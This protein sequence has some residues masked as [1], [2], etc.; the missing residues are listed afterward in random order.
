MNIKLHDYQ[1]CVIH[2][3]RIV[4]WYIMSNYREFLVFKFS[5]AFNYLSTAFQISFVWSL[6]IVFA[7]F[8]VVVF[9]FYWYSFFAL[10]RM[11]PVSLDF[12]LLI[13][14]SVF[15]YIYLY[16]GV[17]RIF[18]AIKTYWEQ[19]AKELIHLPNTLNAYLQ[20]VSWKHKA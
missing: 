11:L 15:S 12:P 19:T 14:S 18:I 16:R 6:L 7:I 4:R 10:C 13:A 20:C 9:S 2:R 5:I 3:C 1:L 17:F 8:R